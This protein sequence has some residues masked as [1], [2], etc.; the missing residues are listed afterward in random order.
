MSAT[1]K[2]LL[3][4]LYIVTVTV[5][6]LYFLFPSETV[7][8]Y[9]SAEISR[10]SPELTVA[11][12]RVNLSF[13]PGILLN[14]VGVRLG[15]EALFDL[16]RVK[17]RPVLSSLIGSKTSWSFVARAYSGEV[18]GRA[19]VADGTPR[20]QVTVDAELSNIQI[21]SIE[22]IKRLS[23]QTVS[24]VLSGTIS[25]QQSS[26]VP[27]FKGN[28]EL[29]DCRVDLSDPTFGVDAIEFDRVQTELQ[30]DN[31]ALTIR[32]CDLKGRQ[33]DASLTGNVSMLDR[34]G[35]QALNI[36]GRFQPHPLF[37]TQIENSVPMNFLRQRKSDKGGFAFR[38]SGSL[39]DPRFSLN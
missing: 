9:V 17:I 2:R 29:T 22:A 28:L 11:I 7:K 5:V 36:R 13:P 10:S 14:R 34:P 20:R 33:L 35:S 24:G 25:Y 26:P 3:Y 31:R 6:F 32:R 19:D 38:I 1:V 4:I 23:T 18:R 12:D 39:D 8:R 27:R 16:D 37:L 30:L 21:R 15:D